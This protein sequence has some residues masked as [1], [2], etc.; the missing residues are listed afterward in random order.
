MWDYDKN[1]LVRNGE[2]LFAKVRN[3]PKADKH[4]YVYEHRIVMENFLNRLLTNDEIIHHKNENKYDNRLENLELLSRI[5]H[6]IHHRKTGRKYLQLKCPYCK[7][8]FE[9]E[10]RQTHLQKPN[11][12]FTFCSRSCN[13]LFFKQIPNQ[14]DYVKVLN[15]N[16]ICEFVKPIQNRY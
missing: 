1:D 7:C 9:R 5:D 12:S 11:Q 8:V 3:H 2:Y 14:E 10:K 16:I 13:N 6:T 4:G 15:E